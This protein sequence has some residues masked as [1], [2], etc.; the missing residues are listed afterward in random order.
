MKPKNHEKAHSFADLPDD[1]N[2]KVK[3]QKK[4]LP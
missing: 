2:K 1:L 3:A 4:L